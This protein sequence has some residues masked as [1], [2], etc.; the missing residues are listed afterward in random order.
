[1]HLRHVHIF[2]TG[3]DFKIM[4]AVAERLN[5]KDITVGEPVKPADSPFDTKRDLTTQDWEKLSRE[6]RIPEGLIPSVVISNAAWARTLFPEKPTISYYYPQFPELA[7][8]LLNICHAA[9]KGDKDTTN[10]FQLWFVVGNAILY[11][12]KFSQK[13]DSVNQADML[14][15]FTK[16]SFVGNMTTANSFDEMSSYTYALRDYFF[17]T[18]LFPNKLSELESNSTIPDLFDTKLTK[19]YLDG[20]VRENQWPS[21]TQALGLFKILR[22]KEFS[23]IIIP[24]VAWESMHLE[25]HKARVN[26]NYYKFGNQAF[27]MNIISAD[28]VKLD[29]KGLHISHTQP[30]D[31]FA[32]RADSLPERRRF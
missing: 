5:I 13:K 20:P 18:L 21:Y 23:A 16:N 10:D 2:P 19:K 1:M 28:D 11:P 30:K 25:L 12:K 8:E 9:E 29:D 32:G 15:T 22:P 24:D 4:L 26:G 6:F 3:G 17:A 31:A 7:E 14:F 27:W